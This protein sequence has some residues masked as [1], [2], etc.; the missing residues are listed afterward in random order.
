MGR[1]H[2]GNWSQLGRV[3]FNFG[4]IVGA[5]SYTSQRISDCRLPIADYY[6][7][8][9]RVIHVNLWLMLIFFHSFGRGGISEF[10]HSL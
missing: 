2:Y 3:V 10:S 5:C 6:S 8:L 9:I 4:Q 1:L 7:V